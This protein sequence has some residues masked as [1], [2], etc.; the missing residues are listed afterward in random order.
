MSIV[1][2][3]I[4]YLLL[5]FGAYKLYIILFFKCIYNAIK[6]TYTLY[7]CI[8]IMSNSYNLLNL[9]AINISDYSN[10]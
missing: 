1:V 10:I 3:M 6:T 8:E 4:H 5:S 7:V 2:V 9:Y